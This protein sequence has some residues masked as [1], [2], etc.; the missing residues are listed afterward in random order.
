MIILKQMIILFVLMLIGLICR[1]RGI[2][3]DE[4]SRV[5]SGIVVNVANP[6]LILSAS[7]NKESLIKG[8]D[9][10]FIAILSVTMYTILVFFQSYW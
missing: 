7:M 8:R 10:I 4:G 9:L 6:A 5:I 2:M 1:K 3:T